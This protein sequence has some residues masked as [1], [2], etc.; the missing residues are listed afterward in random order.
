MS[1]RPYKIRGRVI[2][3]AWS[4]DWSPSKGVR[5][6]IRVDG[7]KSHALQ[8]ESELRKIARRSPT[9]NPRLEDVWS[10]YLHDLKLHRSPHTVRAA[11]QCWDKLRPFVGKKPVNYILLSDI[12]DIKDAYKETPAYC[13]KVLKR[14]TAFITW[15]VEQGMAEPL[16]FKVKMIPY[17]RPVIEVPTE[18][19]FERFLSHFTGKRRAAVLLMGQAGL[20]LTECLSLRWENVNLTNRVIV[21]KKTKGNKSRL[22]F[23]SEEVVELL[24]PHQKKVGW[25]FENKKK[26]SHIQSMKT[27][28]INACKAAGLQDRAITHHRLRH[29]FATS[30]VADGVDLNSVK[31]LLGHTDIQTTQVYL[32]ATANRLQSQV[33]KVSNRM[34]EKKSP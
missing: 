4:V 12:N 2:Q 16:P 11:V 17:H 27:S 26:T 19:E 3:N 18:D 1:V 32:H 30:L 15:L 6:V 14:L 31:E 28:F 34:R 29:F 23:M 13:N 8:V 5:K 33:D 7:S 21:L 9:S 24:K 22:A 20:R 25:I 10:D